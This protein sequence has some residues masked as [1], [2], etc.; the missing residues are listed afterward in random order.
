MMMMMMMMM[1]DKC[2]NWC[3]LSVIIKDFL[4]N[5][6]TAIVLIDFLSGDLNYCPLPTH[7]LTKFVCVSLC[8]GHK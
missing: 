5:E 4:T 3:L 8:H 6:F 2:S 7:T 1:I